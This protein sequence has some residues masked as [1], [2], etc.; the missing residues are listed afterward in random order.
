M[1]GA[2]VLPSGLYTSYVKDYLKQYDGT[3]G[4]APTGSQAMYDST[5][6]ALNTPDMVTIASPVK[7]DIRYMHAR[8]LYVD[9]LEKQA[10]EAL[11]KALTSR[12]AKGQCAVGSTSL[13]DCVLPFLP[14]TTINVT[15]IATWTASNDTVLSVNSDHDMEGGTADLPSNGQAYGQKTGTSNNTGTMRLSNSGIAA[16]TQIPGAVDLDGDGTETN[17]AQPF[18]VGGT[19]GTA[20]DEFYVSLTGG[21]TDPIVMYGVGSHS[22]QCDK[23]NNKPFH[24]TAANETLPQ[25]GTVTLKRYWAKLTVNIATNTVLNG[26]QC[27]YNGSPVNIETNGQNSTI[28]VPAMRNYAVTAA[29]IGGVQGSIGSPSNEG[30]LGEETVIAF[31]SIPK[32][33]TINV[34]LAEQTGS[35]IKATLTSCVA[36]VVINGNNT[37]YYFDTA[38]WDESAYSP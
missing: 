36:R 6:Y 35:P 31:T 3:V 12:R 17:D 25:A 15:E 30:R 34:T 32:D 33:S 14:F 24:C 10:R 23:P 8:G 2:A 11:S 9:Y 20:G 1:P 37:K 7:A 13:P 21:G 16:S 38:V 4:T 18:T 22:G 27:T 29:S 28:A 19:T 5:T 26:K